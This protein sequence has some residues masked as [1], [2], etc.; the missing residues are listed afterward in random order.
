MSIDY[1][2]KLSE[3]FSLLE[4]LWQGTQMPP[5]S[6][7]FF[8]DKLVEGVLDKM[9]YTASRMEVVRQ[10]LGGNSITVHCGFRPYEWEIYRKRSGKSQH[11]KGNA[12]DFSCPK[13]G[14][15]N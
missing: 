1:N 14:T 4:F 9:K 11:I 5:E 10:L 13:W 2:Q 15:P 3:H 7:R 6:K 12:V 8:T